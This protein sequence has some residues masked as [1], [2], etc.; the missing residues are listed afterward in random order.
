MRSR[1]QVKKRSLSEGW[2]QSSVPEGRAEEKLLVW[3]IPY[4][5]GILFVERM[6]LVKEKGWPGRMKD[7]GCAE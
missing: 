7:R 1:V 6:E 3:E 2:I 4:H 5:W